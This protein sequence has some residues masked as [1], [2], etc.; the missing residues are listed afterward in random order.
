RGSG[1][2]TPANRTPPAEGPPPR[3][4]VAH[5]HRL[6]DLERILR[7]RRIPEQSRSSLARLHCRKIHTPRGKRAP[8]LASLVK[9]S[10]SSSNSSRPIA[11][12]R[13]RFSRH[14]FH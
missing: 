10:Y 14:S 9:G 12:R 11:D 1:R 7:K 3:T 8:F 2:S 4:I 5:S 6:R 13:H